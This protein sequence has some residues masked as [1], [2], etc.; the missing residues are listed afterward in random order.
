MRAFTLEALDGFPLGAVLYGTVTPARPLVLVAGAT[1]VPQGFY[2][3]FAEHLV[4]HGYAVLTVDYRGIGR[5]RTGPLRGFQ[6]DYLD[7]A[8]KDLA[9]VV[10]WALGQG[11]TAVVG[12][13]FGGH[14]FGLLPRANDTLGLYTF[15]TGAGWHGYMPA[16]EQPKVLFM[17]NVL[18][19]L[20]T[21]VHG[22]LP[23]RYLGLGEDLP[24]G[25]YRHW[26]EW[27]RNPDYW[28]SDPRYDM[29]RRFAQVKAPVVAV[30]SVDDR[31]ASPRSAA[32][33][34]AGYSG[35]PVELRT[36][37]PS[38]VGLRRIEHM[39]YFRSLAREALW[40]DVLE[41][42]AR[43]GAGSRE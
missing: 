13:S 20:V 38:Q 25:V 14:A 4:S 9:A 18:G 23:S 5:S 16:L 6:A 17:W 26:R 21:R 2:R 24:L 1:G 10:G 28:F 27:C 42:L 15:G 32:A 11:P 19:P 12:H 37:T 35:A 33:F 31:W 40:P 34:M 43:L 30:N 3:R 7:W 29:A 36:L 22:Y 8:E 41:W 39:G